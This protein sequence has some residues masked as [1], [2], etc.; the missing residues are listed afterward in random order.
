MTSTNRPIQ[1][2]AVY[3]SFHWSLGPYPPRQ[4]PSAPIVRS[5]RLL[6]HPRS[7]MSHLSS[8]PWDP[9]LAL[10]ETKTREE[11]GHFTSR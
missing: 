1:N 5:I 6:F 9:C 8:P 7:I 3:S 2:L 4:M 11:S 10:D